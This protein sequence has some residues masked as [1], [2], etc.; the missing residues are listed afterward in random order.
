[1]EKKT[2][3]ERS[4]RKGKAGSSRASIYGLFRFRFPRALAPSRPR[5]R[6]SAFQI[7]RRNA[8]SLPLASTL[9][10]G[11]L[12]PEFSSQAKERLSIA[13]EIFYDSWTNRTRLVA[14]WKR[15]PRCNTITKLPAYLLVRGAPARRET[16]INYL[17]PPSNSH[18]STSND[19]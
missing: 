10:I 17:L 8:S 4:R 14:V 9:S 1:M 11:P 7:P 2:L 3:V 18:N 5:A 19:Q 12:S 15:E 6:P 13:G 16:K